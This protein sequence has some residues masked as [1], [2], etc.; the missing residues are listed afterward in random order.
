MTETC[1][2]S[3]E[4]VNQRGLHA[5]ASAALIREAGQFKSAVTVSFNDE[6]VGTASVMDILMLGAR[7]GHTVEIETTGPDAEAALDALCDLIARKF[8]E[9]E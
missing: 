2:R 7:V 6:T 1:R 8:D 5:R 9:P 4:L 3:V